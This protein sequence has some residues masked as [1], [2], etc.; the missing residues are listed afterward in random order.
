MSDCKAKMHQIRFRLGLRPRPRWRSLQRSPDPLAEFRGILRRKGK[1]GRGREGRRW[2]GRG[3]SPKVLLK[4]RHCFMFGQ[5]KVKCASPCQMWGRLISHPWWWL[6]APALDAVLRKKILWI[7]TENSSL[8]FLRALTYLWAMWWPN[9][10]SLPPNK[11]LPRLAAVRGSDRVR[12]V[13]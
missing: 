1:R 8:T 2:E 3:R 12:S 6:D 10:R 9:P 5:K 11:K 7:Q 13:G 4:W